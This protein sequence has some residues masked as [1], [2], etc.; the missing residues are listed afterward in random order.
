[1]IFKIIDNN[2]ELIVDLN[3]N[4]DNQVISSIQEDLNNNI[5]ISSYDGKIKIFSKTK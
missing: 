5:I 3:N 4:D 1:M 2:L